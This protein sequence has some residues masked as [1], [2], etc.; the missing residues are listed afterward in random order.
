MTEIMNHT[1][2][3]LEKKILS[4]NWYKLYKYTFETVDKKGNKK[5]EKDQV[6]PINQQQLESEEANHNENH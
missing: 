2:N 6:L 3:I 5:I 4:E 1:I